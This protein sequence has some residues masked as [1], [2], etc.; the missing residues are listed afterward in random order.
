MGADMSSM[1][2]ALSDEIVTYPDPR[3]RQPSKEIEVFDE[4]TRELAERMLEIMKADQGVG[5][6][7][8]QVGVGYRIFVCNPTGDPQD[9]CVMINPELTDLLGAVEGEEGCLS[10]PEVRVLVKRARKCTIK[11]QDVTG[12]HFEM[13]GEDLIA[14]IWQHENDHLDGRLLVDRM[15]P[16]DKIANKRIVAK[17]EA[18]YKA[19][20]GIRK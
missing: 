4:S 12:K 18:D 14:R 11:A 6:A 16:T 10:L 7:G 1:L 2:E 20:N 15:N 5:L 3:L 17:L 19:G 9:D 8:P 13:V